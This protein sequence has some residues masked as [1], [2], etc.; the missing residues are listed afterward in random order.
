MPPRLHFSNTAMPPGRI[1][2]PPVRRSNSL[3][4]CKEGAASTGTKASLRKR[5]SPPFKLIILMA[6][7]ESEHSP[8]GG[9]MAPPLHTAQFR[10]YEELNFFL[11]EER[12]KRDFTYEFRGRPSIKDAVEALG[13]P[14]TEIEVI[15]VNGRSVGF[16]YQLQPGDR[17]SVYPMFE[18]LDVTPLI[19][20]RERPLR[21]PQFICDVHLGK[22]A[23]LLRLL[24]FDTL[25]DNRY[26]DHQIID[27][28]EAEQRII[29]TC[30][31]GLLK[32]SRVTRGCCLHAR[33]ALPQAKEVIERFDLARWAKPF[34][35]CTVCNSLLQ[36]VEKAEVLHELPP[37]AAHYYNEFSRCSGCRRIYW[38][39]CHY[40]KMAEKVVRLLQRPEAD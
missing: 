1:L 28:A 12:R 6:N 37:K 19:R 5:L 22:L 39:G 34:S 26:E 14:H 18:R 20:L 40:L 7:C 8:L 9:A 17:V 35:R 3:F 32:N 4:Y 27:I 21:R 38:K 31:R 13:V 10:F 36:P 33:R 11:S 25:Y 24:G 23:T 15:L 2:F 29:L 16:D 30:D